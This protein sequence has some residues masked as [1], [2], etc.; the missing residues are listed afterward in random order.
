MTCEHFLDFFEELYALLL[1]HFVSKKEARGRDP[2]II[3]VHH[4]YRCKFHIIPRS[5][6]RIVD[7]NSPNGVAFHEF[8]LL[9]SNENEAKSTAIIC[10][11]HLK[12]PNLI[13]FQTHAVSKQYRLYVIKTSRLHRQCS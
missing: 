4:H 6:M 1:T 8:H 2:S 3:V 7:R 9:S 10:I 11:W 5:A 12:S 13:N